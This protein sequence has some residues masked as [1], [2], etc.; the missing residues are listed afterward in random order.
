MDQEIKF[1]H[2][3]FLFLT[4]LNPTACTKFTTKLHLFYQL[5]NDKEDF[6]IIFCSMDRSEDDY[7]AYAEKMPWWCLPYAISTLP[8]LAAIYHAH[9]MPHL[10]VIDKDGRLLTRDG[11]NCLSQDPVGKNFPWRPRRI[12]D[13]LPKIYIGNDTSLS[14]QDLDEKYLLLYFSAH[15][16]ALSKEFTPWLVKAYNI[17]KK[18]RQDFEVRMAASGL[19]LG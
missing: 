14:M 5:Q 13:L 19:K 12:V 11:V 2:P 10:V 6:E 16:D 9:G 18:K 3:F 1:S 4:C 17:M 7:S 15:S 8:K